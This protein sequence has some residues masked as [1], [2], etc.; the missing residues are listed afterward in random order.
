[1]KAPDSTDATEAPPPPGSRKTN[2]RL[3]FA[4]LLAPAALTF[5]RVANHGHPMEDWLLPPLVLFG[6]VAAGI[7]CAILGEP[8]TSKMSGT[9]RVFLIVLWS[10]ILIGWSLAF[11]FVGCSLG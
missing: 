5:L 3:F 6:S 4:I 2:W 9:R 11:C 8:R 7:A 10:V 1:M